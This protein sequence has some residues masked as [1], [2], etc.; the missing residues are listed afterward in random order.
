MI[1]VRG[2][3]KPEFLAL[4]KELYHALNPE[5]EGSEFTPECGLALCVFVNNE[6]V[7]NLYGGFK[8][9]QRTK[10]WNQN[11]LAGVY[12]CTKAWTSLVASHFC[13]KGLLDVNAP[14]CNYWSGFGQ[15]GKDK[16]TVKQLLCHESGCS[17]MR[18]PVYKCNRENEWNNICNFS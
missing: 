16:I 6:R 7:V 11:T 4:K 10:V 3:C 18:L 13:S 14:V 9:K 17:A 5:V 1:Q 2:D 12:S 15:N 8:D